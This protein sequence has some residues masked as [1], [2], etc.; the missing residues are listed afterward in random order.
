MTTTGRVRDYIYLGSRLISAVAK[1]TTDDPVG[2]NL[3]LTPSHVY[4]TSWQVPTGTG[5]GALIAGGISAAARTSSHP[6]MPRTGIR[7]GLAFGT[8]ANMTNGPMFVGNNAGNPKQGGVFIEFAI[9]RRPYSD[10]A[11]ILSNGALILY[12]NASGQL[13]L[14]HDGGRPTPITVWTSPVIE[15]D[16]IHTLEIRSEFN[17]TT[18]TYPTPNPPWDNL[19]SWAQVLFDGAILATYGASPGGQWNSPEASPKGLDLTNGTGWLAITELKSPAATNGLLM[20]VF[21]AG[22]TAGQTHANTLDHYGDTWRTTLVDAV[23]PG[24]YSQWTGGFPDWRGRSMVSGKN[25]FLNVVTSSV[26]GQKI[27]YLMESMSA[28][29]ITG[30][31]GAV[32]VGVR[33]H[34]VSSTTKVFVRRNGV[35]TQLD[36]FALSTQT[37]RWYR[38]ANSGWSPSDV[39]EIGLTNGAN[40]ANSLHSL[41]LLVEHNTPEPA[42][43]T[44][45]S[46]QVV[47]V[48]YTGNGTA[49]T[50]DFGVDA[51][52]TAMFVMPV[53]G[54][55][56]TRPIWWWDSRQGASSFNDSVPSFNRIWPQKGKFHVADSGGNDNY[57]S[58][59]VNYVAIALFDPSGRYVIPFAVSK[60]SN[61]DDYQHKLRYPQTGAPATDFIPNFVF[62]GAAYGITSDAIRASYYKGP[63]H[64]GDLTGKLGVAHASDA[65]RIQG[66]GPGTVEFGSLV[67]TGTGGGD[68]AFWA[69]RVDDGV[70]TTRLMAVTSYV[71]NGTSSRNIAAE[72]RSTMTD[73]GIGTSPRP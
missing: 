21:R 20:N 60:S 15:L 33:T 9:E 70:S 46:M 41:A 62:G 55:G 30:N 19:T 51:L 28:R 16:E 44:D 31:I 5:D 42:P 48:N 6:D 49:Q 38:V 14:K 36:D 10:E 26:A 8:V 25:N 27:S 43:L 18:P 34:T 47:T 71:G 61:D 54:L 4:A 39:I 73:H 68:N 29:G 57:N 24:T 35:E 72:L 23:G 3:P 7:L 32:L 69:G 65:D 66:M 40:T 22:L 45:T 56:S 64:A 1:N 13:V 63:G 58:N 11:E 12:V 37:T 67:S 53:N 17:S 59:G 2:Y 50:K 52:P